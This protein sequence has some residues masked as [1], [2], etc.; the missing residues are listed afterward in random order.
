MLGARI[1]NDHLNVTHEIFRHQ[2]MI[3]V[4]ERVV[5]SRDGNERDV[6]EPIPQM[7]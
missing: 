6:Q 5:G 2:G 1:P 4:K 3:D 7:T